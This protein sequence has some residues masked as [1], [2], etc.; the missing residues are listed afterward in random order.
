MPCSIPGSDTHKDPVR[1]GT[2]TL[3]VTGMNPVEG[4]RSATP[5]VPR[6]LRTPH[7]DSIVATLW[8]NGAAIRI[9][10][11]SVEVTF[12]GQFVG[13]VASTIEGGPRDRCV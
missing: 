3:R 12:N 10:V 5:D 11:G 8:R 9:L 1:A 13:G 4:V 6:S 2:R 7:K